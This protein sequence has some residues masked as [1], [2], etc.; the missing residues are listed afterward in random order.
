M[1]SGR[2]R[3]RARV[4]TDP[5]QPVAGLLEQAGTSVP[6]PPI[7]APT[8]PITTTLPPIAPARLPEGGRGRGIAQQPEIA[9]TS[10]TTSGSGSGSG[11]TSSPNG[12][13]ASQESPPQ[14]HSPP[15]VAPAAAAGRAALRGVIHQPTATARADIV[16]SAM[17]RSSLAEGTAPPVRPREYE[18]VIRT[19]PETCTVK[20]G[21]L[22]NP[23]K[24]LCN[25]FEVLNAPNW[26][27]HQYHV[28]YVPEI[29]SRKLRLG[30]FNNIPDI[31]TLFPN[32]KAFDGSTVY[33]LARL[34]D[35]T[36]RNVEKLHDKEI[37]KIRIKYVSSF[38]PT[39]PQ[40]IHLF[41][42]VFRRYIF[43]VLNFL[44]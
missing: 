25:Y 26:E 40:F 7:A 15:S 2:S 42:L 22:G 21:I 12:S 30:L 37:I 27:L 4:R 41:N 6:P 28:S 3:G 13:P 33:S 1:S 17:E 5:A 16:I 31:D 10:V 34:N 18:A 8:Q 20:Q 19:R 44:K 24:I 35:I 23:L 9:A 32:N 39:S 43:F 38:V 29:D 11:G 36:E 14:Q